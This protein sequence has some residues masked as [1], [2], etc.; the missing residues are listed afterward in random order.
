MQGFPKYTKAAVLLPTV[1]AFSA[2]AD[3]GDDRYCPPN[4]RAPRNVIFIL[5]DDHRYDYMGFLGT[6]PYLETP[7]LDFLAA[8]G[9]YVQNAFVTTSLSSPSRASILTGLFSHEHTVVD[10]AAPLPDG[11]VYFPEY[12]QSA[13]YSTA[14]FGKLHM[15]NRDGMPL[16]G[17]DRWESLDGQGTYYNVR[18][19]EDGEWKQYGDDEY[20][21]DLITSHAIDFIEDH[22][23]RPFFVYLSHKNVHDPFKASPEYEGKYSD[24]PNPRPASFNTPYYGIPQLPTGRPA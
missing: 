7:N 2:C 6:V 17:F 22:K 16:P 11:L 3:K 20:V 1:M 4:G 19:N 14:F 12:L 5:S 13:G 18:L 10:N 15:G 24:L 9:A 21:A 23:D 8:N